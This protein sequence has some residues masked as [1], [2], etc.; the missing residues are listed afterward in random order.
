MSF[1]ALGAMTRPDDSEAQEMV[2]G[3]APNYGYFAN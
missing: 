1:S 3:L 2:R